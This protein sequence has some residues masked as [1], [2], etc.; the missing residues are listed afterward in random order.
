VSTVTRSTDVSSSVTANHSLR[1]EITTANASPAAGNLLLQSYGVEG[2]DFLALKGK[3]IYLSF[4]AKSS[5][6]GTFCVAFR[7]TASDRSLIK[8]YTISVAN[9]WEQ[10][11]IAIT[12]D[13]TGTWNYTNGVGLNISFTLMTGTTF[14]TTADTWQSG[15]FLGT[16]AQA[17]LA[18]TIGNAFLI[19]QVQL[20]EG[21][22]ATSFENIPLEI[23][24]HQCRR[25]YEKSVLF[26]SIT[27]TPITGF[28]GNMR[29]SATELA[30]VA[31]FRAEKRVVPTIVFYAPQT[32]TISK[33][34]VINLA[35]DDGGTSTPDP[36]IT[37]IRM[38]HSGLTAGNWYGYHWTASAEL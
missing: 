21:S 10:K 2:Y 29:G 3:S 27:F 20:E 15:N 11:T 35:A 7:N 8:T 34:R 30:H 16:S 22:S 32:G 25:Y 9:T 33:M 31:K 4:W 12:H 38:T 6:T 14:Q 23:E 26:D 18:G 28:A 37:G 17:N 13:T 1:T 36:S 24:L 19:S 5:I